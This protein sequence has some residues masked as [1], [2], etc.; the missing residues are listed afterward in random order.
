ML[1][2]VADALAQ[3]PD[4]NWRAPSSGVKEL[5][6]QSRQIAVLRGGQGSALDRKAAPGAPV[7]SLTARAG[8]SKPS[9]PQPGPFPIKYR[10]DPFRVS[11]R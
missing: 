5:D 6:D 11:L 1:S 10:I 7:R 8:L 3:G 2:A 9:A 4:S